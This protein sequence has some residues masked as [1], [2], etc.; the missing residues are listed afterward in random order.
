M[1]FQLRENI[2]V[3][4]FSYKHNLHSFYINIFKLYN[5]Y[6]KKNKPNYN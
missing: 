2:I 4:F 6:D 5:F 1:D 3:T